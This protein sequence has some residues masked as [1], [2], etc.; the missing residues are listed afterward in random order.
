[1]IDRSKLAASEAAPTDPGDCL[2][3]VAHLEPVEADALGAGEAWLTEREFSRLQA[4]HAQLRR[5]QYLAGH[6]LARVLAAQ[7]HGGEPAQWRFEIDD[8]PRPRLVHEDGRLLWASLAHSGDQLAVALARRPVGL[9][10]E[11]PRKPRDFL[12]L[13]GFLFAPEEAAAVAAEAEGESRSRCFH[14]YWT[15]KEA[16]GKRSGAGLQP[17]RARQLAARTA[18]QDKAEAWRWPLA[19]QGSLA[20]AA[21]PGARLD[22]GGWQVAEVPTPWAFVELSR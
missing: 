22:V 15:L 5:R 3:R 2:V 20:L 12:A 6:W 1:M 19:E 4:I 21:W 16:Q 14:A 11:L 8:D 10:L 17:S 13:A 18:P 9:D 7:A